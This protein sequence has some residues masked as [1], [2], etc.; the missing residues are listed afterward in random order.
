[1]TS[2][3][4]SPLAEGVLVI[5]LDHRP[6]R[7]ERFHDL[8]S[9]HPWLD[10]WQRLPAVAGTKLPGF[11]KSPWFHGRK[12]DNAWAGRAGCVLS[13][14]KAIQTALDAGWNRVCIL[15]DDIDL[16]DI[17]DEVI[18]SVSTWLSDH[19]DLWQVAY[20]GFSE[21]ASPCQTLAGFT[22]T[23]SICRISGCATTH[24][25]IVKLDAMRW[26]LDQLPNTATIW[27]WLA[28]HRAIDRWYA[29]NLARRFPVVAVNPSIIGQISDF[30]DIGQRG[31]G[32]DRANSFYQ[33]IPNALFSESHLAFNA[34]S[35][36][37]SAKVCLL[38]AY[39]HLRAWRKQTNGF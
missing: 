2:H 21:P 5:N 13:H 29:R 38:N 33:P 27:P 36:L 10:G 30:S 15:E 26:I 35:A 18:N 23:H 7:L 34:I 14:R 6:E 11:G 31:A 12:R 20:L 28:R 4:P 19:N 32:D 24:A 9:K 37:R 22:P 39:D 25:Y 16:P 8:A 3:P 17:S 1:M